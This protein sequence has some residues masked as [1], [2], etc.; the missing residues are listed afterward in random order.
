MDLYHT[1]MAMSGDRIARVMCNT[2]KK[3]H[4]YRPP[5]G[6]K[7]PGGAAAKTV[8]RTR[9]AGGAASARATKEVRT[10]EDEWTRLMGEKA[11]APLK[12]YNA[13]TSFQAGDKISHPKFGEGVVEKTI[14]PNKVEI[15]FRHEVKILIHAG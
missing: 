11:S 3:P 12:P 10:V 13:R 15:V 5:K 7:E 1:I 14:H 6:V 8:T 9:A 2:C 4:G